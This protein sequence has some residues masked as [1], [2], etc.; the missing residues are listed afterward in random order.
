MLITNVKIITHPI[1]AVE[2]DEHKRY[3]IN[4]NYSRLIRD[5]EFNKI[6]KDVDHF[7]NDIEWDKWNVWWGPLEDVSIDELEYKSC[8]N[9]TY[10]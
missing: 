3:I 9:I 1:I 10:F 2:T 6:R 8:G 7:Y 5:P 4:F